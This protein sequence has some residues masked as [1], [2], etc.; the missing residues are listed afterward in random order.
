M[1]YAERVSSGGR[2][3]GLRVAWVVVVVCAL[4][5]VA[6][7]AGGGGGDR[8]RDGGTFDAPGGEGG[9]RECMRD[10]D[11]PD[12]MIFC[13]GRLRCDLSGR[14]IAGTIP[15]CDDGIGCTVDMCVAATD[16]CQNT[17]D[18]TRCP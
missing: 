18:D 5:G 9:T 13:N 11:C 8:D 15:T 2:R 16:E 6:G 3:M 14:C 1:E 7:W 10:E 4:A 17:P 12:D